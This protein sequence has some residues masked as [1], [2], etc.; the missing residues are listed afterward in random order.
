M[1]ALLLCLAQESVSLKED[2]KDVLTYQRVKPAA[3]KLSVESGGYFHPLATPKG[4]LLTDVAPA[5]HPHH[6]G[7]FL[8][9]VEMH[10]AKS[11]DFWGWGQP[12][13]KEGRRIVNREA[14]A[15]A[16]T[17]TAE[18]EWM[19]DDVALL[20]ESLTATVKTGDGMRVVDLEYFLTPN[21]DL[22]VA[23]W[24]FSGFC[25]RTR[26]DGKITVEGPDG[27]VKRPAPKHTDPKSDW[28]DAKWYGLQFSLPEGV[29]AGVAVFGAPTN[30][31]TLWHVVA[32]IGMINPSVCAPAP[33]ELKAK[34]ALRL[35][36]RVVAWDGPVPRETLN[37]LTF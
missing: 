12:A 16:R 17:L 15:E 36:Y 24:A 28:P 21:A 6:R 26:K 5:D 11:A 35:T 23:Q 29:Q 33:L 3:S 8:A 7:I 19:A 25:V 18:N 9:F 2:G 20:F 27:E 1:I 10:G 37:R 22:N 14:R 13:P 32:S 31:P 30:P 4:V 34:Q